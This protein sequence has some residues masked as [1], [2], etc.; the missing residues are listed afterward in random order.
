MLSY[1]IMY[2]FI[3]LYIIIFYYLYIYIFIYYI[4]LLLLT[5]I[6]IIIV[7]IVITIAYYC[8]YFSYNYDTFPSHDRMPFWSLNWI[9]LFGGE[10]R[11]G[12]VCNIWQAVA[13]SR[14]RPG[15]IPRR[16]CSLSKLLTDIETT[17]TD[18]TDRRRTRWLSARVPIS[19]P[20]RLCT[21]L[22]CI[23]DAWPAYLST[24]RYKSARIILNR[25]TSAL[26]NTFLP[27][28]VSGQPTARNLPLLL[29]DKASASPPW[30]IKGN[31]VS[32]AHFRLHVRVQWLL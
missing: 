28:L 22:R 2:Y 14:F 23:P 1:I 8:H 16:M 26:Q 17:C 29:L 10:A 24:P 25:C 19:L 6:M 30:S 20:P 31:P 18:S 27:V 32:T 7:V 15:S 11:P 4:I 5:I 12:Q 9:S 13:G 3:L 21:L